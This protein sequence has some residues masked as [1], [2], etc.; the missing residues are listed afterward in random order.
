VFPVDIPIN[1]ELTLAALEEEL[2]IN[3]LGSDLIGPDS[4]TS[5]DVTGAG[6]QVASSLD[7]ALKFDGLISPQR[8]ELFPTKIVPDDYPTIQEAVKSLWRSCGRV[9]IKAGV[10]KEY[11]LLEGLVKI[12]CEEAISTVCIHPLS[13][14]QNTAIELIGG[15]CML[16]NIAIQSRTKKSDAPL[17]FCRSGHIQLERCVLRSEL[18]VM[19]HAIGAKSGCHFEECKFFGGYECN[20]LVRETLQRQERELG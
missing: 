10:F 8:W 1:V 2:R 15:F 20:G 18:A 4:N 5:G 16:S 17:V 19:T 7:A 3:S 12:C 13:D 9:I 6:D 11:I 14:N